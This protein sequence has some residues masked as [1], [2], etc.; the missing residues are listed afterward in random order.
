MSPAGQMYIHKCKSRKLLLHL[1]YT[2][3]KI[4]HEK[5]HCSESKSEVKGAS[6]F[7]DKIKIFEKG[8]P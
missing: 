1:A 6:S 3:H 4:L 8:L 7:R 2:G 5:T